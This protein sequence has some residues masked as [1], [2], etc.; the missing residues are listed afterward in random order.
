M[1]RKRVL[2][3]ICIAAGAALIAVI[4]TAPLFVKGQPK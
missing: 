3:I 2:D 4:Y 1:I